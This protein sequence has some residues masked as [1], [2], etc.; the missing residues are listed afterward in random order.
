MT[1]I[2]EIIHVVDEDENFIRKAGR[3][4][5]RKHALLHRATRVMILDKENKILIQKR[6][7]NKDIY[8]GL[9]DLGVAGTVINSDSYEATAIRELEEEVAIKGITEGQLKSNFLF[10]I[11]F[12]SPK[13]NIICKIYKIM[14]DGKLKLLDGE[15]DEVKFLETGEIKK[16]T[17]RPDFTPVGAFI[18][19]KFL[20]TL[21]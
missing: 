5:I 9:W 11:I 12:H 1:Q 16:M 8:P 21:R 19:S 14:Y 15:V 2:N 18:F 3:K 4:E 13:H 17:S 7:M 6:S 20:E 10:K